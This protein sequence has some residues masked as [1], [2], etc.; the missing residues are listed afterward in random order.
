MEKNRKDSH[1]DVAI[2]EN[3][4]YPYK[5]SGFEKYEFSHIALPDFDFAMIDTKTEIMGKEISLPFIITAL[6]GGTEKSKI[7][8]RNLAIACQKKGIAL[9]LGSQK[10]LFHHREAMDTFCVRDVAPDIFLL[11]NLGIH[12]LKEYGLD[13]C[14]KM[15]E[16]IKADGLALY[17][18]SLHEATQANGNLSYSGIQELLKKF[19]NKVNFPVVIKE[20]GNGIGKETAKKLGDIGI[21]AIDVAGAGGTSCVLMEYYITECKERKK[22]LEPFFNWGISSAQA[23]L[24]VREVFPS[25][26][27][28]A[29]GGLRNG[30]DCAKAIALGADFV[31]MALP[32]LK[33]ASVSAEEVE[34]KITEIAE[35]FKIAMLCAGA[36]NLEELRK[37]SLRKMS[38]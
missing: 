33:A 3:I 1:I 14:E 11:G 2:N 12:H 23:L 21:S 25:K 35:Q 34:K 17:L 36:K 15:V 30:V 4:E 9:G 13:K 18:N 19:C 10:I 8:N 29:S 28:I 16:D 38:L 31:G 26:P 24:E 32:F 6:T 7:I 20:T 5:K 27:V 37:V 22:V